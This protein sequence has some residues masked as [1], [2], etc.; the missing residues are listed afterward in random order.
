M[1][2]IHWKGEPTT[3]CHVHA[4]DLPDN[5]NAHR[6]EAQVVPVGWTAQGQARVD[7]LTAKI[8]EQEEAVAEMADPIHR[9]TSKGQ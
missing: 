4:E 6:G 5:E 1:G 8:A 2:N 9:H 3:C 7:E